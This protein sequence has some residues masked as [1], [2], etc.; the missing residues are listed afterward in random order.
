MRVD[1]LFCKWLLTIPL[2]VW[3][4]CL[5]AF[6]SATLEVWRHKLSLKDGLMVVALAVA[7]AGAVVQWFSIDWV[8]VCVLLGLVA[9]RGAD[10]LLQSIDATMPDFADN[11]VRDM[12][13]YLRK[14]IAKR[15]GFEMREETKTIEQKEEN[16]GSDV[17]Q[18][19]PLSDFKKSSKKGK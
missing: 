4:G 15:F 13:L 3:A 8:W 14:M 6:L 9:G 1:D 11:L 16:I 10:S 17:E 19:A 2:N 18:P 7:T 5:A 12:Q